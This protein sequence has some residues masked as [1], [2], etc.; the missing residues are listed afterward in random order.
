MENL[1]DALD[2]YLGKEDRA[3]KMKSAHLCQAWS[4]VAGEMALK[5]TSNIIF[6]KKDPRIAVVYTDSA[7]AAAELSADQEI[8]R[9]LI[10][11]ALGY[12]EDNALVA[13]RFVVSRQSSLRSFFKKQ[14][15]AKREVRASRVEPLPLDAEEERHARETVA[16]VTDERLKESLYNAMKAQIEWKKGIEANKSHRDG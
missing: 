11:H 3:Q 12:S 9:R 8:Y 16:C 15:E 7:H 6:D 4:E 5:H 14:D 13:V 2:A 10:S 1:Q